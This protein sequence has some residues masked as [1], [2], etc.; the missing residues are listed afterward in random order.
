MLSLVIPRMAIAIQ[1]V[2]NL[3]AAMLIGQCW[4]VSQKTPKYC[5]PRNPNP[6]RQSWLR[7]SPTEVNKS[8]PDMAQ[9]MAVM[10]SASPE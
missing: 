3:M 6:D 7:S 9:A 5:K 1:P 4:L 2:T 8:N 10:D